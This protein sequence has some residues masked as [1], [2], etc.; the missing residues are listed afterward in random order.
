M[1]NDGEH[2][3]IPHLKSPFLQDLIVVSEG[4]GQIRDGPSD[5]LLQ[6]LLGRS[7]F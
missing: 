5:F 7:Q 1:L 4:I 6:N 3:L 2:G